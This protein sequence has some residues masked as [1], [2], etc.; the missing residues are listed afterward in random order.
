M[1]ITNFSQQNCRISFTKQDNSGPGTT[2]CSIIEPFLTANTP[3][4][5]SSLGSFEDSTSSGAN[6]YRPVQISEYNCAEYT[7]IAWNR[8]Y[9][10]HQ[11]IQ[12]IVLWQR[13]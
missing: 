11:G 3:C 5:G 8:Y 9:Y 4:V 6:S 13:H 7:A 1:L 10:L 12:N 2:D